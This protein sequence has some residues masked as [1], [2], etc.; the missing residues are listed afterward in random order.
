[1]DLLYW[2]MLSLSPMPKYSFFL[3]IFF[4][5]ALGI[6]IEMATP[7]TLRAT[8]PENQVGACT[9]KGGKC[10]GSKDSNSCQKITNK[11]LTIVKMKKKGSCDA[12]YSCY[13][14]PSGATW[15]N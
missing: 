8:A 3:A 14:C 2:L 6:G 1:M 7:L 11:K 13:V 9:A 15:R 5:I 12:H 4:V 10:Y